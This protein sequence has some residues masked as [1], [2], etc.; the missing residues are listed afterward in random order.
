MSKRDLYPEQHT[1]DTGPSRVWVGVRPGDGPPIVLLHGFPDDSTIYDRLTPLLSGRR[2]VTI[3]FAGYGLSPRE[4]RPWADQQRETEVVAVLRELDLT[5]VTLVGHDASLAVAINVTLDQPEL[6]GKL[7]LLN[8]YF[9]SDPAL[10]L[11]DMIR[12]FGIHELDLLSDAMME[13]PQQRQWLLGHSGRQFGIDA[14]AP[15]NVAAHSIVPQYFGSADQPDARAAIR[16]WTATLFPGMQDNDARVLE[17]DLRRASLPV[18]VA[19]GE[20]DPYLT[21]HIAANIGALFPSARVDGI[22][23]ASH[24]PQWDQPRALAE[25]ILG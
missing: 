7:V 17:G 1:I 22:S 6:V 15:D 11:P 4:D 2:V 20:D 16:Q 8:G 21:P 19:F 18:V 25:R 23:G 14:S 24:W 10:R 9:H 3:D 13:D 5:D 12:L